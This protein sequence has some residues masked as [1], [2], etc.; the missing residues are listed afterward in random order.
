M[1][2][3]YNYFHKNTKIGFRYDYIFVLALKPNSD[4]VW[5]V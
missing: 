4:L 3:N 2:T 5:I 1:L